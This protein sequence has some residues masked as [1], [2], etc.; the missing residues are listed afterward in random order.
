MPV[1]MSHSSCSSRIG[2]LTAQMASLIAGS[3]CTYQRAHLRSHPFEHAPGRI[4]NI[5]IMLRDSCVARG[6]SDAA[7]E[8]LG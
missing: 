3:H 6:N 1:T 8:T 4:V 5:I 7:R 2:S